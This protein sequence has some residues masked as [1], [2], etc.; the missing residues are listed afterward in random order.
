MIYRRQTTGSN[1]GFTIVELLIATT[2]LSTILLIV[3]VVMVGIGNLYFKGVNQAR[4]QGTVR[5]TTDE[6]TQKL[7]LND[8]ST[9]NPIVPTSADP[10]G[11]VCIGSTRYSYVLNKQ[12]GAKDPITHDDIKHVLWRDTVST[13]SCTRFSAFWTADNPNDTSV[14][15]HGTDGVEVIPPHSRLSIFSITRATDQSPYIIKIGIA[16]G[17]G[18]LLCNSTIANECNTDEAESDSGAG[19]THQNNLQSASN[20]AADPDIINC[21]GRIGG[22]F[23]ATSGLQTRVVKRL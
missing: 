7:Q 22:Q 11:A 2:I 6:I 13:G 16:Y 1:E 20:P 18:D 4:V 12:I 9:F 8:G 14:P 21:R 23:C 17:D 19:L 3:T 10:V 5:D 15:G